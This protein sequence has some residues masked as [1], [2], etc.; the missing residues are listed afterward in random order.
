MSVVLFI[1][2]LSFLVIIHELGHYFVALWSKVKVEEFGIGYPPKAF[3]LFRWKGTDF[4]VNW[5]SFGGFVKLQGEEGVKGASKLSGQF[6][7]APTLRKLIILLAGA[8]VNFIFGIIAF[9][10]VFSNIGIPEVISEARIGKISVGS[11]AKEVGIEANTNII[12]FQALDQEKVLISSP[13]DL[14]GQISTHKGETVKIFTSGHCENLTCEKIEKEYEVYLRPVDST[15][16]D[17]GSLGVVFD[18]VIYRFYPPLQMPFKSVAFGIEQAMYLGVQIVQAF[19]Q[20]VQDLFLHAKVTGD[21]AGPVGIIHQAKEIGLFEEG[22]LTILSF[23]GMLSINL[24]VM[25]VLPFPPLDGGRALFV[26]LELIF[27]KKRTEKIEYYLNY[28]GYIFLLS[29]IVIITIKD[30]LRIF[31]K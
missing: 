27:K 7:Q 19:S 14:V 6:Y 22:F 25:N 26:V 29:L 21:V 12:G 28:G 31:G 17:Q 23:A 11:P 3:R 18:Q 30:V 4:T 13:N 10:I 8:S 16:E 1:I 24:A 9:T 20:I 5:I 2:I 15:P